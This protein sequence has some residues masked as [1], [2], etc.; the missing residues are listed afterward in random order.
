MPKIAVYKFLNFLFLHMMRLMK[1]RICTLLKK[2][3]ID[4]VPQ[5]FGWRLLMLLKKER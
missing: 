5:K 2:K 3:E 1:H 4:S